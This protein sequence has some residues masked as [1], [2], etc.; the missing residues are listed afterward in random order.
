M[1][2]PISEPWALRQRQRHPKSEAKMGQKGP[3]AVCRRQAAGCTEAGSWQCPVPD[4][5]I[6]SIVYLQHDASMREPHAHYKAAVP[7]GRPRVSACLFYPKYSDGPPD[8]DDIRP[9]Y[10]R[11][12]SRMQIFSVFPTC[13]T[14]A[15]V[16]H[17]PREQSPAHG[18]VLTDSL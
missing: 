15:D 8:P 16:A 2:G 9:S 10:V 6:V 1:L 7:G 18:P 4:H 5:I 14:H 3:I 17:S 13:S 11:K 12:A